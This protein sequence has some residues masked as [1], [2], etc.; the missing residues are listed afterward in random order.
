MHALNAFNIRHIQQFALDAVAFGGECSDSLVQQFLTHI[1]EHYLC[2][3]FRQRLRGRKAYATRGARDDSNFA[4]NSELFEKHGNA[5][6]VW[7]AIGQPR[8][9]A[10]A[11]WKEGCQDW[12]LQRRSEK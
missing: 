5:I 4:V 10:A 12:R 2:S 9:K 11:N 8:S 7:L 1:G 3:S 6:L